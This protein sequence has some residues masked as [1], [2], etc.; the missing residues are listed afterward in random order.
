VAAFAAAGARGATLTGSAAG[1]PIDTAEAFDG[2][3]R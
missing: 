3:Q 2:G 1:H